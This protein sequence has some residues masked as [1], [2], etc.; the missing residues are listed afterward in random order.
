MP[1]IHH[2]AFTLLLFS[3][4]ALSIAQPQLTA[5]IDAMVA[6]IIEEL[7][8]FE[9]VNTV[10][11]AD[12]TDKEYQDIPIGRFLADEFMTSFVQQPGK[13]FLMT[14]RGH[15]KLLMEELKLDQKGVLSP[16]NIPRLGRLKSIDVIVSATIVPFINNL[17]LNVQAVHLQSGAVMAGHRGIVTLTPSMESWLGEQ[18][19]EVPGQSTTAGKYA[20][21]Q[22]TYLHQNITISLS[23][24]RNADNRVRCDLEATSKGR[25]THLSV[26]TQYSKAIAS[27]QE[28]PLGRAGLGTDEGRG[29]VTSTLYA[30]QPAALWLDFPSV[31][32]AR[33]MDLSLSFYSKQDGSFTARFDSVPVD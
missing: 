6:P 32:A 24:C 2:Y 11:I 14:N 7:N 3:L 33:R 26:Y 25:T 17:R 12:F 19:D 9:Q 22:R 1:L 21:K 18:R 5:E 31:D 23:S 28:F 10:A 8:R 16:D 30:D 27:G 4:P 29:R 20:D 15:M 13:N